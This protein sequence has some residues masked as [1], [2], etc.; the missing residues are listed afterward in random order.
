VKLVTTR[1]LK[2]REIKEIK[3]FSVL[4]F[5]RSFSFTW[6]WIQ[7]PRAGIREG[8]KN[9]DMGSGSRNK[10]P[11]PDPSGQRYESG[12]GEIGF[13]AECR[14]KC[15]NGTTRNIFLFLDSDN[16]LDR[17]R[18]RNTGQISSGIL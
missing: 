11:E 2:N 18:I 4:V 8:W 13:G 10:H 1:C 5:T 9:Q 17:S 7:D 16:S 12:S 15:S 6:F 3:I 14:N